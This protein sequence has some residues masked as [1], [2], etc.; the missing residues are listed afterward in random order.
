MTMY[1]RHGTSVFDRVPQYKQPG[2]TVQQFLRDNDALYG[3]LQ[4]VFNVGIGIQIFHTPIQVQGYFDGIQMYVKIVN[5]LGPTVRT[6]KWI[7]E[8]AISEGYNPR[9]KGGI[10]GF[11]HRYLT[12]YGEL[13]YL[14]V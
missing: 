6:Q 9:T 1:I 5:Q 10:R 14:G 11:V 8:Q 2:M 3:I 13:A 7:H 4:S 12:A